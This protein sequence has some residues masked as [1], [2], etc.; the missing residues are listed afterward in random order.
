MREEVVGRKDLE[1]AEEKLLAMEVMQTFANGPT[2]DKEKKYFREH[3]RRYLQIYLPDCP[4]E[5]N[6][7]DRYE[8]DTH[9]AAITA[10][11]P[12]ARGET[13]KYLLGI[14]AVITSEEEKKISDDGKNFSIVVSSM[15]KS[16]SLLMGPARFV[17]HDCKPN[18]T[19][20]AMDHMCIGIE[21]TRTIEVDEEITITYG[22]SYFGD[23]NRECLCKTCQDKRGDGPAMV[24]FSGSTSQPCSAIPYSGRD[25]SALASVPPASAPFESKQPVASASLQITRAKGSS[26]LSSATATLPY[27]MKASEKKRKRAEMIQLPRVSACSRCQRHYSIYGYKWPAVE[28]PR[29]FETNHQDAATR[30]GSQVRK[31]VAPTY[32]TVHNTRFQNQMR[33]NSRARC[34]RCR[35]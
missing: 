16:I 5:V 29:E 34:S 12:I 25:Q 26:H 2:T 18:A 13:I 31:K 10:R 27:A 21:A 4:W 20:V 23:G 11:R 15:N 1:A 7:T 9:E 3:V 24:S 6:T 8:A 17:N 32:G 19:L 30:R 35:D 14:R 28:R 22:N 33:E